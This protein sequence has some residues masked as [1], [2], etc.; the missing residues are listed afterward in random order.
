MVT[1]RLIKMHSRDI[2]ISQRALSTK[3]ERTVHMTVSI[4]KLTEVTG[5]CNLGSSE[6]SMLKNAIS[7]A[8]RTQI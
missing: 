6:K 3:T 4:R 1:E 2:L 7:I 8:K 5:D